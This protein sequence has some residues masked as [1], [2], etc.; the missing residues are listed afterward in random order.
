[1]RAGIRAQIGGDDAA[2]G[3]GNEDLAGDGPRPRNAIG[4]RDFYQ[5]DTVRMKRKSPNS[6]PSPLN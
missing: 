2:V 6:S 5:R 1:M 3:A 4:G